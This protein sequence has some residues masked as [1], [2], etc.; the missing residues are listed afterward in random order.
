MCLTMALCM[1]LYALMTLLRMSDYTHHNMHHTMAWILM[2]SSSCLA[3]CVTYPINIP[4]NIVF[5]ILRLVQTPLYA[6][7]PHCFILFIFHI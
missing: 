4:F 3:C 1:L 7:F 6:L 5:H 2:R